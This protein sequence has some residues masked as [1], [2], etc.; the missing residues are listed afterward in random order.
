MAGIF[1]KVS[2]FAR[3][4]QGQKLI[5]QAQDVA[6]DP[7]NRAK[8]TELGNKIKDPKNR[9]KVTELGNKLKDAAKQ[10]AAKPA[11]KPADTA[12]PDA[13][14]ANPTDPKTHPDPDAPRP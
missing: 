5:K 7:K 11:D 1:S 8:V 6:K 12:H 3:S 10:G 2:A 13:D 14:I 9:A 4:P